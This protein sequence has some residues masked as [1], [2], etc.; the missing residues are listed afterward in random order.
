MA[1]FLLPILVSA[2]LA[3]HLRPV[4][5]KSVVEFKVSH[6]MIFKSTVTGTFTG[7]KGAV[8]FDPKN[9]SASSF[10][11]SVNA[12]TINTGIGM[13]DNDLKKEK[14]FNV[15]KFPVITIK[16]KSIVKGQQANEYQFTGELLLKGKPITITFPFTAQPVAGG[17]IFKGTFHINRLDFDV[18][19]DNSI[20]KSVEINLNVE[21]Q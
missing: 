17:Y 13:R 1:V 18:G 12:A 16:S 19:P 21:V 4:E 8:L 6:Q 9:L 10:D 20:A 14:Y 15:Q 5:Q 3:Q 11:V 2:A 7:L